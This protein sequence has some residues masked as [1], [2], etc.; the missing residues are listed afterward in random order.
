MKFEFTSTEHNL[1]FS[2]EKES[3]LKE[4]AQRKTTLATYKEKKLNRA[5]RMNKCLTMRP[6][7]EPVQ[8]DIDATKQQAREYFDKQIAV[9]NGLYCDL[10][11]DEINEL[12]MII[13]DDFSEISDDEEG[14]AFDSQHVLAQVGETGYE[15][16]STVEKAANF[17]SI[18]ISRWV[19]VIL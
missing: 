19:K 6:C 1:T 16:G 8:E 18:N 12:Q 7:D 14:I 4:L 2:A 13:E 10:T 9:L 5:L 11:V 17:G 3:A 15:S